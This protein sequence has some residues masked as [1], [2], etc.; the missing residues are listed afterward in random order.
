MIVIGDVHGEYDILMRLLDK[1]P[2]TD[3]LC[4]VGDLIDRGPDSK[5]VLEFVRDN[6]HTCV[7]GNHE[8]MAIS[9]ERRWVINGAGATIDNF[10]G[11]EDWLTSGWVDWMEKLPLFAEFNHNNKRYLISHSFAYNA[12]STT[13]YDV[14][15]GRDAVYDGI[16]NKEY[17]L[18]DEKYDD[19]FINIFG[20]TP[21]KGEVRRVLGRHW[22]IDTG[23]TYKGKLSAIDLTDEKIYWAE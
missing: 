11:Y 8:D 21:L 9:D 6:N 3:K 23:A 4:F 20:H 19:G 17:F 16:Q 14:L 2:Q 10:G 5:K 13:P 18:T 22:L 7:L 1:L 15:W 12:E